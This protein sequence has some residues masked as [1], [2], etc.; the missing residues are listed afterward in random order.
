MQMHHPAA[1]KAG[2]RA[3]HMVGE[4]KMVLVAS[5][6]AAA[7]MAHGSS[8]KCHPAEEYNDYTSVITCQ[9]V[10]KYRFQGDWMPVPP[11]WLRA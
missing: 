7:E 10:T 5:E 8:G 2:G 1:G 4:D 11:I 9:S 3:A 6:A